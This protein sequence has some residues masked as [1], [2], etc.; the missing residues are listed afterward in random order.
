MLRYGWGR[1]KCRVLRGFQRVMSSLGTYSGASTI[2]LLSLP[3]PPIPSFSLGDTDL[4]W[5]T[6]MSPGLG[7][8]FS[9]A[10]RF[11]LG[12]P[13]G[14]QP[15]L[16][17]QCLSQQPHPAPSKRF[18]TNSAAMKIYSMT[19]LIPSSGHFTASWGRFSLTGSYF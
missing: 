3:A 7:S 8:A 17:G 9:P 19:L 1:G 10:P 4:A 11:S 18:H 6:M 5:G 12:A 2:R 14:A 16:Q 15:T 13:S